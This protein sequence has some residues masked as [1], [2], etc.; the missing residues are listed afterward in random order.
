MVED[1]IFI[2]I[3]NIVK[4]IVLSSQALT[5]E[6]SVYDYKGTVFFLIIARIE[7]N[8]FFQI[9]CLKSQ[10][11]SGPIVRILVSEFMWFTYLSYQ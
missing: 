8:A 4:M 10:P 7:W 3:S 5:G 2:E 9:F 11:C 6:Y 1:G